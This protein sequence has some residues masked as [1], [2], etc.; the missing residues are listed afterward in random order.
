MNLSKKKIIKEIRRKREER[1]KRKE[2]I[3]ELRRKR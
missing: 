3:E 1:G 2:E